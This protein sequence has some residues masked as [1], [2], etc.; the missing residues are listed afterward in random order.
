MSAAGLVASISGTRMRKKAEKALNRELANAPK[1]AITDEAYENQAVARSQA[2]GRDRAIQ[3]GGEDINQAAANSAAQARD[4]TNSTSALLSTIAQINDSRN[5]QL[6]G[7]SQDDAVLRNQKTQQL[8]GAN[9]AMIDEKD[10]KWNYN[11]NM[12]FQMRVAMHRDKA[13]VGSEMEMAGVAAQAQ[14]ES[15]LISSAGSMVGGM[16]SDA[17]LKDNIVPY[18]PGLEA[19]M[20]MRAVEFD[21]THPRFNDGRK[22]IGFI[23]QEIEEIVP[24]AVD[25][26][27]G[28]AA[29]GEEPFR[30]VNYMELVPVLV[31][32]IQDLQKQIVDLQKQVANKTFESSIL[33]A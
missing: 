26:I 30:K 4:V 10:K 6:R 24:Q 32:A 5:Q 29:E 7:L 33:E 20:E 8:F 12:P 2:Y 21:Y 14:T 16:M 18:E 1:Y 22:H 25:R 19:V 3:M 13:K 15:A 31:N 28:L 11:E 9:S 17:R 23:A 27:H